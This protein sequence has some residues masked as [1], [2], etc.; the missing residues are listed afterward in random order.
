MLLVASRSRLAA[1]ADV[2]PASASSSVI[3]AES[4]IGHALGLR[5]PFEPSST[6]AWKCVEGWNVGLDVEQRAAVEHIDTPQMEPAGRITPSI[7]C[8]R[9]YAVAKV[10]Y[11]GRLRQVVNIRRDGRYAFSSRRLAPNDL[12]WRSLS[13]FMTTT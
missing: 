12:A 3:A 6:T 7:A 13:P 9:P 8:I 5:R 2:S 11:L 4:S 10:L 1:C